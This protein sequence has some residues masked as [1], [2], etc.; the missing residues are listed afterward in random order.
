MKIWIQ[1][2]KNETHNIVRLNCED[3]SDFKYLGDLDDDSFREFLEKLDKGIDREKNLKLLKYF[4]Y[5]HLLI[6]VT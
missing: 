4:G 1:E 6:K 3:H 2:T 5:L